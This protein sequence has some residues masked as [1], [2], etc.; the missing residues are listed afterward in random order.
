MR[1]RYLLFP[2]QFLISNAK[3]CF[4]RNYDTIKLFWIYFVLM[5]SY[6]Y[7]SVNRLRQK[8]AAMLLLPEWD[9]SASVWWVWCWHGGPGPARE[10]LTDCQLWLIWRTDKIHQAS[11]SPPPRGGWV[12]SLAITLPR[13]IPLSF[14]SC[15]RRPNKTSV[16]TN[17][18]VRLLGATVTGLYEKSHQKRITLMCRPKTTLC[19]ALMCLMTEEII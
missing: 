12:S 14:T 13:S 19:C 16:N 3:I 11:R 8:S 9:S 15:W 6:I 10:E 17:G 7:I 2:L 5:I 4:Y 18:P 1:F